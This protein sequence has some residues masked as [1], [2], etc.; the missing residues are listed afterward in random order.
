MSRAPFCPLLDELLQH[1]E[2]N[3]QKVSLRRHCG[4]LLLEYY[5]DEQEAQ[6]YCYEVA[7]LSAKGGEQCQIDTNVTMTQKED[8]K[9]VVVVASLEPL[10]YPGYTVDVNGQIWD[11][12]RQTYL[13]AKPRASDGACRVHVYNQNAERVCR[14]VH[15]LVARAF[16]GI[17]PPPPPGKVN[18]H[19][20]E[21][22]PVVAHVNGNL[23]DNRLA[24]LAWMNKNDGRP[25]PLKAQ[26]KKHS[27]GHLK[28]GL[29]R[30][31]TWSVRCTSSNMLP[32]WIPVITWFNFD[33]TNLKRELGLD[34]A[35]QER[36]HAIFK[37]GHGSTTVVQS[38]L[39]RFELEVDEE[40][41]RNFPRQ[42]WKEVAIQD[43]RPVQVSLSGL[44]REMSVKEKAGSFTSIGSGQVNHMG[45]KVFY[46]HP[47]C[48]TG[49]RGRPEIRIDYLVLHAWLGEGFHRVFLNEQELSCNEAWSIVHL[50]GNV[51]NNHLFNLAV[52]SQHT[53]TLLQHPDGKRNFSTLGFFFRTYR[54]QFSI[55]RLLFQHLRYQEALTL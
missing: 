55:C 12:K 49:G 22:A 29:L 18:A 15:D 8:C 16:L 27:R 39:D 13:S 7:R 46:A 31:V 37:E 35:S 24:N 2:R 19:G 48:A 50:D 23:S 47:T 3:L 10:G 40:M 9:E 1:E 17:P 54:C 25:M 42:Q 5:L 14:Y 21:V 53:G 4:S 32:E 6:S 33:E 44:V 36:L 20:K 26:E 38:E 43:C 30:A 28:S 45:F 51:L 34:E 41:S 11:E 52:L